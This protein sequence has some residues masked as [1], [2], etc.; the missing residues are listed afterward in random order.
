MA[1]VSE[2]P[3]PTWSLERLQHHFGGIPAKRIH[4]YPP[5]GT[6]KKKQLIQWNEGKKGIACELVD[7]VLVEK[8]VGFKESF[9]A[10]VLMFPLNLYLRTHP[11]G[12]VVGEHGCME[13]MPGLVRIPDV[14]FVSWATIGADEIP[15]DPVP[16]LAP[17]LAVEVIS[18]GN[19]KA[20]MERKVQEYF[21]SGSRQVWLIY[22]RRKAVEVYSSPEE[23]RTVKDVIDGGKVLSG[24]S[25]RL[26]LLFSA[27]QRS[28]S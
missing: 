28:K 20:E 16:I 12:V 27:G 11:L 8:A 17:V 5:P 3:S 26:D 2:R 4:L 22:P 25:L 18:K 13:I 23:K 1:T 21:A 7:G 19:T 10:G 6:A 24:F 15:T 9:L 14:S